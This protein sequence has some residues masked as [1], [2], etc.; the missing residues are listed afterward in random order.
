[1]KTVE[2]EMVRSQRLA[3]RER[4]EM[5]EEVKILQQTV[6]QMCESNSEPS[7]IAK[8]LQVVDS[9]SALPQLHKCSLMKTL[10]GTTA[11]EF[12]GWNEQLKALLVP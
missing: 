11:S 4:D 9:K 8:V 5:Q 12:H 3:A 2:D 1:M 7:V 10:D 6:I